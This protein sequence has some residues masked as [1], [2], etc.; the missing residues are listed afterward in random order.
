M[1]IFLWVQSSEFRVQ[2]SDFRFLKK[3]VCWKIDVFTTVYSSFKEFFITFKELKPLQKHRALRKIH[4]RF[5]TLEFLEIHIFLRDQFSQNPIYAELY[6][7]II[8][9]FRESTFKKKFHRKKNT[10]VFT[11]RP[12]GPE[13]PRFLDKRTYRAAL[14]RR[15]RHGWPR[16]YTSQHLSPHCPPLQKNTVTQQHVSIDRKGTQ[17][18]LIRYRGGCLWRGGV[19]NDWTVGK[20]TS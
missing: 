10:V 7:C 6:F 1:F 11:G 12:G 4:I 9:F 15:T 20:K 18:N 19:M 17:Y 14:R 5:Y 16:R 3:L 2:S 8:P 13:E